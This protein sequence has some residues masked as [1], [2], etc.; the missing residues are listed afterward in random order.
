MHCATDT[1]RQFFIGAVEDESLSDNHD[2]IT[3]LQ[4]CVEQVS[5]AGAWERLL[6]LRYPMC[7]RFSLEGLESGVIAL[8]TILDTFA[9]DNAGSSSFFNRAI[10]LTLHRGI[11]I[12]VLHNILKNSVDYLLLKWDKTNGPTY[13]DINERHS[14]DICTRRGHPL[15]ISLMASMP[16]HLES[17]DATMAGKARGHMMTRILSERHESSPLPVEIEEHIARSV[18]P[19]AVHGD[20][21]LCGQGI[22]SETLQLS[23]FAGYDCGGTLHLIFNKQIGFTAKTQSM[24]TSRHGLVNVSDLALSIRAPVLHVNAERPH[25]VFQAARL[26]IPSTDSGSEKTL[27][28]IFGAIVGMGTTKETSHI[29]PMC[30]STKK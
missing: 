5:R 6:G 15:H 14:A 23:T 25:D 4:F 22:V 27:C 19:V 26:A 18:L 7:K 30:L 16:A 24:R 21:S 9:N 20:S 8:N 17:Q 3:S 12:N 28:W 1:E 29:Q 2:D 11:R 13:D 10:I